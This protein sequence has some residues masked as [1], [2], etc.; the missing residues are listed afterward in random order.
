MIKIGIDFS[1]KSPAVSLVKNQ[2]DLL[3]FCFPRTGTAKE[4][5]LENLTAA[6]VYVLQLTNE[7]PLAKKASIAERERSSLMDAK[8]QV[9]SV[10]LRVESHH[11]NES[12]TVGIEGFSFAS[13]GNRLAQISGYQWLLRY[14]YLTQGQMAPENFHV[15]SPMTVKATAGKGNFKKEEMIAAFLSSDDKRLTSNPFWLAMKNTPEL[16]QNKK[17]GWE[18]PIDDIVDSYWVLR[19]LENH[20]TELLKDS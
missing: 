5:V 12:V 15:F 11:M 3:F 4:K 14:L 13:T 17:G 10:F 19:T 6:G 18:K 7:P 8:M 20:T 16:F 2:E 1:I 9:E